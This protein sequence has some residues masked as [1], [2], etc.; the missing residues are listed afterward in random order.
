MNAKLFPL[1]LLSLVIANACY[2]SDAET[3]PDGAVKSN[4]ERMTITAT[5]KEALDT[6][7]AMSVHGIGKEELAMDNGQHVAESLNSIFRSV[8]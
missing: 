4:V 7:L 6:D 2:A 8:D 5:R 1:S 3:L